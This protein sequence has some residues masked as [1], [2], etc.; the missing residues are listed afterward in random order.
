[1]GSIPDIIRDS[2]NGFIMQNNSS[3]VIAENIINILNRSDLEEI[4]EKA[5]ILISEN[6]TFEMAVK[7][8]YNIIYNI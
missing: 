5:K 4:S 2:Q 1:V 6:F 7:R 8:Y 3:A